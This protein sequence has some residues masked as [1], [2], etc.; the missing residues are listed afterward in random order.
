MDAHAVAVRVAFDPYLGISAS[1]VFCHCS[2]QVDTGDLSQCCYRI[3][4]DLQGHKHV[5]IIKLHTV[6]RL[7]IL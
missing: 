1:K 4:G 3:G 5:V 2:D 7:R 6:L